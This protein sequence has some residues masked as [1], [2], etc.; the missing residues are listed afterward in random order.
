MREPNAWRET[1]GLITT[2]AAMALR[3]I[4]QTEREAHRVM[5][6][7][8]L[9]AQ[10]EVFKGLLAVVEARLATAESNSQRPASEKIAVD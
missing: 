5:R 2:D 7:H 3:R 4:L 6:K 10:A 8:L 9:Q 1:W